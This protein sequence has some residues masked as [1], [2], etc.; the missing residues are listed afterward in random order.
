MLNS[1]G[2]HRPAVTKDQISHVLCSC[3]PT[4]FVVISTVSNRIFQ[5]IEK[6]TLSAEG[7]NKSSPAMANMRWGH[8]IY[9]AQATTGEKDA[10]FD[11][12][13]RTR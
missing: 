1:A 10:M 9:L 11:G 5:T 8:R 6:N 7:A 4:S 12:C 13:G 3:R 2:S